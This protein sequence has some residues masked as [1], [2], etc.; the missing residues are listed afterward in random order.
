M[1]NKNTR[2]KRNDEQKQS[3]E[4]QLTNKNNNVTT[5][6]RTQDTSDKK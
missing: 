3:S 5:T 4:K 6:C 2:V 1:T